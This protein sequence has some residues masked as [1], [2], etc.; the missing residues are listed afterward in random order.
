[1]R[2]VLVL[3]MIFL[4]AGVLPAGEIAT[5]PTEQQMI[6]QGREIPQELAAEKKNALRLWIPTP[7][8]TAPA[9]AAARKFFESDTIDTVCDKDTRAEITGRFSG[10]CVQFVGFIKNGKKKIHCNFFTPYSDK[11]RTKTLALARETYILVNDGGSYFWRI[12]YDV[13][14]G[15]CEAFEVNGEA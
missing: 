14:S 6:Y 4:T 1:M 5:I 2:I 13:E 9:L 3:G 7:E 15:K 10:Y 12:D 11:K 8:E